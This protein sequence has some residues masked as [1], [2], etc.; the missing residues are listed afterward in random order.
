MGEHEHGAWH[1]SAPSA[2][3]TPL[4]V[5]PAM[6]QMLGTNFIDASGRS[7]GLERL[8]GSVVAVYFS[9]SWCGPC[10]NFTPQL[11]SFYETLKE[12]G[13]PFEVIF[14]SLDRDPGSFMQYLAKM[15]WLAAPFDQNR[16]Q[17][18]ASANQVQGIPHLKVFGKR[19]QVVAENAVGQLNYQTYQ[20]WAA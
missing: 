12:D 8:A 17:A 7:H 19:G 14:V 10:Q 9:A 3:L 18:V 13:E 4:M 16:L 2:E 1:F 5:P 15:P 6:S 20:R 11:A